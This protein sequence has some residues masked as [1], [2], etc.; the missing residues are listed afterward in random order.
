VAGAAEGA[1]RSRE[2]LN[3]E[4]EADKLAVIYRDLSLTSETPQ[5]R[6]SLGA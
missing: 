4:T 3:W 5:A 1:R 6:A 2:T